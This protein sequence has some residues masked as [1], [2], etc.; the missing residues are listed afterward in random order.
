M[1]GQ[2]G[3]DKNLKIREPRMY[4]NKNKR[5]RVGLDFRLRGND[6]GWCEPHHPQSGMMG[7]SFMLKIGKI[8]RGG[9]GGSCAEAVLF[10]GGG[11]LIFCLW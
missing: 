1:D 2:D 10:L 3:Q 5:K 9:A 8:W 7:L 6:E 11:G 4:A